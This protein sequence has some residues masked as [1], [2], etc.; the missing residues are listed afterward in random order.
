[1]FR[2]WKERSGTDDADDLVWFATSQ[3]MNSRLRQQ[4]IDKAL[5]TDSARALAEYMNHWRSDLSD[6]IP[7]DVID[8]ATDVGVYER[9][10]MPGVT[11]FA[12]ADCAGGTG[13]D[14]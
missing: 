1:M 6:F 12:H 2:R 3:T 14:S 10:P 5:S 13:K 8:S 11:Y 7:P 4:D 9:A